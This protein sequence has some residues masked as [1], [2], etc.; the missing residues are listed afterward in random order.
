MIGRLGV[1]AHEYAKQQAEGK[2]IKELLTN[3]VSG[4]DELGILVT[5]TGVDIQN[6]INK[7]LNKC[8]CS[9]HPN[10]SQRIQ[11]RGTLKAKGVFSYT[12]YLKDTYDF[13]YDLEEPIY[14]DIKYT[15][16][17]CRKELEA[18]A[19]KIPGNSPL[20]DKIKMVLD[21]MLQEERNILIYKM[22]NERERDDE[23]A[24]DEYAIIKEIIKNKINAGVTKSEVNSILRSLPQQNQN[25]IRSSNGYK[26]LEKSI[27]VNT[28]FSIRGGKRKTRKTRK[29][30]KSK[31]RKH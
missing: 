9:V 14:S 7:Y 13:V 20:T 12:Y 16:V 17:P 28:G 2:R 31:T 3:Y 11:Y 1:R 4:I 26:Q 19:K 29:N 30:R 18:E 15:I 8:F 10:Q 5:V 27:P 24:D 21:N 6:N 25:R 23:Y 22:G